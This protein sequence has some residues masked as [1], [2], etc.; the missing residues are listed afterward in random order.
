MAIKRN[1]NGTIDGVL[2]MGDLMPKEKPTKEQLEI[3][4]RKAEI[5]R[6]LKHKI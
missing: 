6:K 1:K 4:K 3:K 2:S 5:E